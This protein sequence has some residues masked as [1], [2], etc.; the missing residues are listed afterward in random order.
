MLDFI[1]T[2]ER[3]ARPYN[4]FLSCELSTHPLEN[5]W[6]VAVRQPITSTQLLRTAVTVLQAQCFRA[7]E[8]V[9]RQLGFD[10]VLD[11]W[12]PSELAQMRPDND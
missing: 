2:T 9:A 4:K 6:G 12:R 11:S 5:D 7:V 8:Q 1:F 10:P 3:R